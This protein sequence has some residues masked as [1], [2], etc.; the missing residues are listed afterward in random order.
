MENSKQSKPKKPWPSYP[1]FWHR[2]GQWCKKIRGKH[3]YFGTDSRA[4]HDEYIRVA[5]DLHA[6]RKPRYSRDDG[7]PS[8]K[9]LVNRFL[10]A[11]QQNEANGSNGGNWYDECVR[12]ATHFAN[13]I[14][15][16][17]PWNDL[18]PSDFGD[19]RDH[20]YGSYK[21]PTIS[22]HVTIIR[23]VFKHAFV[24][25]YISDEMKYGDRFRKPS[26]RQMRVHQSMV[27]AKN[28]LRL[29]GKDE[30]V[31]SNLVEIG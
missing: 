31:V 27:G 18:V 24:N 19:Y 6:G 14:G 20:L 21:P 1:L 29:F 30:E 22:R 13:H 9:E 8:V 12:V 3:H 11:Q 7:V 15:K 4:A 10:N 16:D 17:R 25:D 26:K 2:N 23:A 28:G 5:N